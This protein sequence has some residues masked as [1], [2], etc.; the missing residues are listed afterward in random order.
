MRPGRPKSDN[1]KPARQSRPRNASSSGQRTGK[2]KTD[3]IAS[4]LLSTLIDDPRLTPSDR[5]AI[6]SAHSNGI[7]LTDLAALTV[8][9]IRLARAMLEA[10]EL[11]PR[12]FMVALNKSGSH[13]AAAAQLGQTSKPTTSNVVIA[14]SGTG[15]SSE[16]DGARVVPTDEHIGDMVETEG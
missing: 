11:T 10:G 16:R 5:M 14:F 13:V 2:I 6:Q 8:Y 7:E 15:P 4:S 12:E 3:A 1:S 9:E